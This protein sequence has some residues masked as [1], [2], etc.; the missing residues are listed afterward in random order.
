M[1]MIRETLAAEAVLP[2]AA[3]QFGDALSVIERT[4]PDVVIVGHSRAVDA[5]LALAE[6]L[7]RAY[8][9]LVLVALADHQEPAAILGAMRSGY[10][11]FVVLPDDASRLRSTV[12][13]AAFKQG[14]DE[15]KGRVVTVTGAKGGVGTTTLAV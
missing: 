14:T 6:E 12:H 4:K 3:V 11:E 5:S 1:G 7:R 15:E 8:P 13:E 2:S 9:S 10:K